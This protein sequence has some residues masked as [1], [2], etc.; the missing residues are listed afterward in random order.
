MESFCANN[1][2]WYKRLEDCTR[3]RVA[4]V[5]IT[6]ARTAEVAQSIGS[7]RL[8]MFADHYH[9]VSCRENCN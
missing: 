5:L 9:A 4:V 6:S 3:S 7:T 8:E 1:A 2:R